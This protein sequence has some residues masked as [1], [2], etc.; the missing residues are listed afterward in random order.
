MTKS[1]FSS[2][3]QG[4]IFKIP[5]DEMS[6]TFLQNYKTGVKFKHFKLFN[7]HR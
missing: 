6:I 1:H 7:F 2:M 4:P 5:I 3:L